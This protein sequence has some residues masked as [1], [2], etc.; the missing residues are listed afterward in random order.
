ME[1]TGDTGAMEWAT[2][3]TASIAR[4]WSSWKDNRRVDGPWRDVAILVAAVAARVG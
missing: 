3:A 1:G 4:A 2:G